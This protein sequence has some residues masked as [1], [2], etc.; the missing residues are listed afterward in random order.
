MISNVGKGVDR[1]DGRAK[2]TGTAR[3]AAENNEKE[4][5]YAVLVPSS[6]ARGTIKSID[7]A[8]A[9]KMPGVVEV[10]THLNVPKMEKART[11]VTGGA[12]GENRM[13]LSGTEIHYAG[14]HIALVAATTFEQ[15]TA[16]AMRLGVTYVTRTPRASMDKHR[17]DAVPKGMFGPPEAKRG[18]A[19]AAFAASEVKVDEI[20]RTPI[21]HHNMLEPHAIVARW[22]GDQLTV[23]DA[24][25]YISGAQKDL[26]GAF[27]IP[28]E[29]VRV[30]SPYVGGGFGCKGNV[31]PHVFLAAAAAKMLK[32][33]VKLSLTRKQLFTSNGH[34]PETEQRVA[35]GAGRDGKLTSIIH[36]SIS[37]TSTFDTFVEPCTIATQMMYAT[38]NLHSVTKV[39]GVNLGTPTFM[40]APGE[41][42]GMYALESALDELAYKLNLDP[43]QLRLINHADSDPGKNKPWSSKSLKECYQQAGDRFGWSKRKAEPRSMRDGTM[44]LGWGMASA[45]YPTYQQAASA[46]VTLFADGGVLVQSGA[47]EMGMGTATVQ[48]QLAAELLGL[49][50]ERVRFRLGDTRLPKAPVAGGSM[51]TA[52]V[53]SAVH[54]A[55]LALLKKLTDLAIA[56]SASPLKG[57][58]S[59][60][61]ISGDGR[62]FVKS[63]RNRG[64]SFSAILGRHYLP[65]IEAQFDAKP[66]DEKYSAHAFGAHFVEVAVDPDIPRVQVRRVVS[67]FAA[68]R[69]LNA[70]TARSQYLGG[71]VQGLGMA[72]FEET[73]V[74]ENLGR[75]TNANFAEYLVPVNADILSIEPI[76]VEEVDLHAN[77]IGVK[78]I[79]EIGIVGVAAAVANAVYHATGKRV[80]DLPITI[81]KLL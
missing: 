37:N 48:A 12:A 79:G 54:G 19:P 70:K 65:S 50:L 3:F 56:D 81:E 1:V 18:D 51:Q 30:L 8:T 58:A 9:K 29:N 28:L 21:E 80:R 23:H 16:A 4:M 6:I 24:S 2:V 78:G 66:G 17:G 46:K 35:L 63:D 53:G 25:Q 71:I 49:P 62:L 45:T 52:S 11:F 31:W 38:P 59:T 36:E 40:R 60:E 20:Y 69:I 22:D 74:D 5:L 7:T 42:P 75:F 47:Q 57:V 26:A 44:L 73:H 68:G 32:R 34:R 64:E 15:A 41:T 13:P 67:A 10:M 55:A 39:V 33:P 72:L 27:S 14:Q 76:L 61:V 77:P 43:V